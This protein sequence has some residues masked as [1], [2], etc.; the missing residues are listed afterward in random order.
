MRSCH[1]GCDQRKV[2]GCICACVIFRRPSTPLS[3]QSC[4]RD[5]SMLVWIQKPGVLWGAG[6]W[7]VK[8]LYVWD[9]MCLLPSHLGMVC[10]RSL[11]SHLKYKDYPSIEEIEP[12]ISRLLALHH[13][14]TSTKTQL[15]T[16]AWLTPLH[17]ESPSPPPVESRRPPQ[18]WTSLW[19]QENIQEEGPTPS[20]Y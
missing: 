5:C 17:P 11:Y 4:W 8:T 12:D 1:A 15:N 9:N 19:G 10:V 20:I 7:T 14:S 13:P 18:F 3:S 16:C 2:A 6:T